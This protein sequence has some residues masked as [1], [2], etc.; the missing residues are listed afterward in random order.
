L[1]IALSPAWDVSGTVRTA[2]GDPLA[3]AHV[4]VGGTDLT[5]DSG[6]DG[7]YLIAGVPA[8]E[9]DVTATAPGY[10][11]QTKHKSVA[12]NVTVDF[13]MIASLPT[14]DEDGGCGCQ[15]ARSSS[16]G[17]GTLLICFVC[18]ALALRRPFSA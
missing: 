15:G 5:A 12:A 9:H 4:A 16:G 3:G 13:S 11:A 18:L 14:P 7:A 1:T 6:E 8:G 2:A 17:S 10:E